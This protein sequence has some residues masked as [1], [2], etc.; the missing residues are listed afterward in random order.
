MVD[1]ERAAIGSPLALFFG[2]AIEDYLIYWVFQV[3]SRIF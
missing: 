3:K 2:N 1:G